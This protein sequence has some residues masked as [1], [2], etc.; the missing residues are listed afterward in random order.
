MNNAGI[1][2]ESID[3]VTFEK[4]PS[5]VWSRIIKTDVDSVFEVSKVAGVVMRAQGCGRIINIASVAGIVPLQLQCAYS[6]AKA[7][8]VNLTRA[9]AVELGGQGLLINGIAPGSTV[10]EGT[11]RLFYSEDGSFSGRAQEM[12]DHIPLGRPATVDEIAVAAQF[13]ADPEN[14][15]MNGH[16]LTV[17]GGWIAGYHRDF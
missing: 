16:I 11:K 7:A 2:T 13:L 5:D 4:F 12:L 8:V 3:R 17:D 15:Y 6:A 9:M 1:G 10:T 14:T